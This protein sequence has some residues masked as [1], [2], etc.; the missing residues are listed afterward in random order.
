MQPILNLQNTMNLVEIFEDDDILIINKAVGFD[1]QKDIEAVRLFKKLP[2]LQ[3]THRLDKRVSGLLLLTKNEKALTHINTEFA[4]H[5]VVKKYKAIVAS[6]PVADAAT[7]THWILKDH[8]KQ[9]A[10]AYIQEIKNSKKSILSY[11]ILQASEKYFM[12]DLE[13]LTGR[14]HQIRSQLAAIKSPIVGDVKYGYK[15]TTTDGSIFL[16]SYCLQF[17]HPA[18]K[19]EIRFEIPVPEIWKKFGFN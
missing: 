4:E 13:L 6:K 14:F 16:Q 8:I 11:S 18:S 1:A 19:K 15:R 7:L 5:K 3:C 12:L 2:Y 9:K 17:T 10:K